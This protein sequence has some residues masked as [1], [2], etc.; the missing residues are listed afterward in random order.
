MECLQI[1]ILPKLHDFYIGISIDELLQKGI[2][3][4]TS[5]MFLLLIFSLIPKID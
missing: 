5:S 1:A 2:L 3:K 4:Q